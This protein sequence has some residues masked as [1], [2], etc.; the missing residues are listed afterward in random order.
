LTDEFKEF[1]TKAIPSL[2]FTPK[3][4]V[5]KYN[6]MASL[7][8]E[9]RNQYIKIIDDRI[10]NKLKEKL[11]KSPVNLYEMFSDIHSMKHAASDIAEF[12]A[13]HKE[14]DGFAKDL[15][16]SWL[17]KWKSHLSTEFI[18][19]PEKYGSS[20]H[21]MLQHAIGILNGIQKNSPKDEFADFIVS[22]LP[23]KDAYGRTPF[24]YMNDSFYNFLKLEKKSIPCDIDDDGISIPQYIKTKEEE[25]T[26]L[27]QRVLELQRSAVK[28]KE[29]IANK[30]YFKDMVDYC[31]SNLT[32]NEYHQVIIE[33]LENL[34]ASV[35]EYY[36]KNDEAEIIEKLY[37]VDKTASQPLDILTTTAEDTVVDLGLKGEVETESNN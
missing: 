20:L 22:K 23:L 10:S 14:D 11:L 5:F 8:Y 9:V 6:D 12:I 34:G 33:Y 1:C 13:K 25:P 15:V 4:M 35:Q 30:E 31:S 29:T 7:S 36:A 21:L 19:T 2:Q 24:F 26:K 28:N 17:S 18:E 32:L 37:P 16:L 3:G 27:I